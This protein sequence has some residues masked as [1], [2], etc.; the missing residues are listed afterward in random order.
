MLVLNGFF[1]NQDRFVP[2][3]PVPIPHH[4]KVTITIEEEDGLAFIPAGA[5]DTFFRALETI[6]GEAIPEDF[7]EQFRMSNFK[8]LEQLA[9]Q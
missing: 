9:L 1:D 4:K 2:D 7:V 3:K 5:W 6:E 8:T